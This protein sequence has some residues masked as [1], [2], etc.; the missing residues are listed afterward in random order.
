MIRNFTRLVAILLASAVLLP[1]TSFADFQRICRGGNIP[2]Y[3]VEMK[4]AVKAKLDAASVEYKSVNVQFINVKRA[5]DTYAPDFLSGIQLSGGPVQTA[6]FT[7]SFPALT[8]CDITGKMKIVV[9]YPNGSAI[10]STNVTI[11]GTMLFRAKMKNDGDLGGSPGA[12]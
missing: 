7:G 5:Q 8:T 9:R 3:R 2:A 10:T 6:T 1:G 4:K 12:D 11:P